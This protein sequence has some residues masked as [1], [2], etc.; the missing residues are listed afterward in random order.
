[1]EIKLEK[2]SKVAETIIK[3]LFN[4]DQEAILVHPVTRI[5][6]IIELENVSTVPAELPKDTK[7]YVENIYGYS[8]YY[9]HKEYIVPNIGPEHPRVVN[10]VDIYKTTKDKK[11]V[12]VGRCNRP[13]GEIIV[14]DLVG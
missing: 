14:V 12:Y 1:V 10:I 4:G 9:I 2:S 5:V 3:A 11:Q 7:R 6:R 13:S 8:Y